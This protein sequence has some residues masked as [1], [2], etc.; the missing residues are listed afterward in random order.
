MRNVPE[1]RLSITLFYSKLP[2]TNF[3][4]TLYNFQTPWEIF[5]NIW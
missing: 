3:K 5:D 1:W 2:W 4:G